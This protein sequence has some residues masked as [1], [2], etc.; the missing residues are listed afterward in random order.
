MTEQ[1]DDFLRHIFNASPAQVRAICDR[2]EAEPAATAGCFDMVRL[3]RI[4]ADQL[5]ADLERAGVDCGQ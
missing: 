2:V 3:L 1:E 4:Y 5:Q